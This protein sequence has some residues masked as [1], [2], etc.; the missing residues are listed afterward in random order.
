MGVNFEHLPDGKIKMTQQHFID[1]IVQE[2][3]IN[4]KMVGN[5][6]P[7]ATTKIL[8]QTEGDVSFDQ[9]LTI[10]KSLGS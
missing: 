6:T 10:A 8:Q 2:V 4:P 7:A 1:Q 9:H 3:G 5:T